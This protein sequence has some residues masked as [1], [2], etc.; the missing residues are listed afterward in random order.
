MQNAEGKIRVIIQNLSTEINGGR[1]AAKRVVGEPFEVKADI[2]ADGHDRIRAFLRYK[3]PQGRTWQEVEFEDLENHR[4]SSSFTPEKQGF[5][6]YT[7]HAWIDHF[8]TWHEKFIKKQRAGQFLE[9][10][11]MEGAAFLRKLGESA[12]KTKSATLNKAAAM[13]EDR[14]KYE[15]AVNYVVSA[16]FAALV[17]DNPLKVNETRYPG[18]LALWV[19]RKKALFSA[20][21]EFF[22]RSASLQ[23][24]KHGTFKDC[25]RLLPRVAAMGFDILYFPPENRE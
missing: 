2:Y 10:E 9:V 13:I 21:Y 14:K 25:E 8:A 1:Y 20:W 11:L 4:W 19:D 16:D 23:K 7:L 5:Y 6:T 24:D 15:D 22:P 3:A 17:K 18:E 12:S